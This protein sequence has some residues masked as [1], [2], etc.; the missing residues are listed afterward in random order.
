MPLWIYLWKKTKPQTNP[1]PTL[2][3]TDKILFIIQFSVKYDAHAILF[4]CPI[5]SL[6]GGHICL[7]GDGRY[8][9]D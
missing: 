8:L 2:K 4:V 3:Q 1:C 9:L 7:Q 6:V 5:I